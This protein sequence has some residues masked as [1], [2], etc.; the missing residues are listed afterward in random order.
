M[1]TWRITPVSKWLITMVIVSP[2]SRVI[3]LPN[4]RTPWLINGGDPNHLLTGM[5]LQVAYV[6]TNVSS[7]PISSMAAMASLS[8]WIP[9]M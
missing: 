3:P 1:S 4:G 8:A 9:Y 6:Q 2:L 5:I 7:T